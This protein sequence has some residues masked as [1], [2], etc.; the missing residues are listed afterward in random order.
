MIG[1]DKS[2]PY[3]EALIGLIN[4]INLEVPLQEKDQVLIVMLLDSKDKIYRFS[5]WLKTKLDSNGSLQTTS[6]EVVRA[7]VQITKGVL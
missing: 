1:I 2:S 4:S 3:R 5:N 6:I 7:A